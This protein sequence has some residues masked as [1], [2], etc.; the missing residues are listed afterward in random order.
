MAEKKWRAEVL[1]LWRNLCRNSDPDSEAWGEKRKSCEFLRTSSCETSSC[2][3]EEGIPAPLPVAFLFPALLL[4]A[5]C[6]PV[7]LLATSAPHV[8]EVRGQRRQ[9]WLQEILEKLGS[10]ATAP[11]RVSV[12]D[13]GET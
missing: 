3:C 1:E 10:P 11:L 13:M 9:R 4:S 2:L 7:P 6:Q 8:N 5:S 12:R